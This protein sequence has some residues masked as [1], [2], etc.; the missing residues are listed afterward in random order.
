[1][2][3]ISSLILAAVMALNIGVISSAAGTPWQKASDYALAELA[4]AEEKG[5][6]PEIL[7][8]KDFTGKITREEFAE[9]SVNTYEELSGK[10]AQASDENPFTDT[11]NQQILKA[12]NLG[13][14]TGT[15]ATTFGPDSFLTREQA[16][17]ML[18]RV[19]IAAAE[20]EK[21]PE[22]AEKATFADDAEISGYAIESVYYMSANGIINGTGGNKFSPKGNATR[23]Q[24]LL[25]AARMCEKLGAKL[26]E[27]EKPEE[28]KP[29][30]T[31][32]DFVLGFIG[33]SLTEGG[34][35]WIKKTK[36][37][38]QEKYPDKNIVTINAG[39]GGTT[40]DV[41]AARYAKDIL[42]YNPDVVFIEFAVNDTTFQE[43]E[44]KVHVE[45]MV[46]QSLKC[47]KVPCIVFVHTPQ[48]VDKDD[49]LYQRWAQGV[50][51]KDE[52]AKHYGLKSIN[53]YDYMY[54]DY[55]AIKETKTDEYTFMDYIDTMYTKAA[56]GAYDVHGGYKKYAEAIEKALTEDFAKIVVKP[57]SAAALSDAKVTNYRYEYVFANDTDIVEMNNWH[58]YTAASPY[59][60]EESAFAIASKFY[61][62]P[63]FTG[64]IKQTT[65]KNAKFGYMATPG[66]EAVCLSYISSTK[67]ASAK[68][69]IDDVDAGRITIN[70]SYGGV[71]YLSDWITL[72]N[73][74]KSH[75][76]IF[77]VDIASEG[78]AV[79][80]YGAIVERFKK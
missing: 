11:D 31:K 5:L 50:E 69:T 24:A 14:T 36:E 61:Q 79:F 73:D 2:K 51:W 53:I 34:S 18:S 48:P 4:K 26:D 52:I 80:R 45:A 76:V 63:Y 70:S 42:A 74:G 29:E 3:K 49:S 25:I 59:V 64:G 38:F 72:P 40:S 47:T 35:A 54:D 13:I 22:I 1:M 56:S 12:Y 21:L 41:G 71:N 43:Y 66:T 33:G 32:E 44:A 67:G 46:R 39:I 78:G 20:L 62:Y 16:A 17:T 65:S 28:P 8:G 58:I 6:I 57:K 10:E 68:V 19:Y 7:N 9:V 60:A 75:K 27:E 30:E 23:E 37:I 77:E 15:T 55:L